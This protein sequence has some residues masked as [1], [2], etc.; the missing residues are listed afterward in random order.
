MK[1]LFLLLQFLYVICYSQNVFP[2]KFE[3]TK[4]GF[5]DFTVLN[6]EGK[7]KEEIYS[8]TLEWINKTYKNPKEVIK[9]E[10]KDDYVRFEGVKKNLFSF[11]DVLMIAPT[12]NDVRYMIEVSV[13]DS[14]IKFDIVNLEMYIA[15]SKYS[16]GGWSPIFIDNKTNAYFK[17]DGSL[18]TPFKEINKV[19]EHFNLLQDD[20]KNYILN[21]SKTSTSNDW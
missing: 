9:A 18:R 20:L 8:K 1:K 4:D 17:K 14:K 12:Y 15:P 6:L 7:T 3:I 21:G 13:K 2:T 16:R 19:S 11:L 5:T 10:I